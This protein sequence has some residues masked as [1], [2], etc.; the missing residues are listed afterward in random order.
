MNA[1]RWELVQCGSMQGTLIAN[2]THLIFLSNALD[3]SSSTQIELPL[4]ELYSVR[5]LLKRVTNDVRIQTSV[6]T[7]DLT[8]PVAEDLDSFASFLHSLRVS[9]LETNKDTANKQEASIWYNVSYNSPQN[10]ITLRILKGSLVGLSDSQA[11]TIKIPLIK[12]C[13]ARIFQKK[14]APELRVEIQ[15][16]IHNF[17]FQDEEDAKSF[18]RFWHWAYNNRDTVRKLTPKKSSKVQV[19]QVQPTEQPQVEHSVQG[20]LPF[21]FNGLHAV[22]RMTIV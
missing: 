1:Q 5:L 3:D 12:L 9:K 15:S 22:L 8:F 6:R 17:F 20:Q 2:D 19:Q 13:A 14:G 7:L 11:E 16:G 10:K 21:N 18:M 4:S